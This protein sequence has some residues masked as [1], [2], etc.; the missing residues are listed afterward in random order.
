MVEGIEIADIKKVLSDTKLITKLWIH[1]VNRD[2]VPFSYGVEPFS[3]KGNGKG[4]M[5][6]GL[7]GHENAI[8]ELI[9]ET[10]KLNSFWQHY[11]E[12]K[13]AGDKNDLHLNSH[14]L[15][16]KL[17]GSNTEEYERLMKAVV[18]QIIKFIKDTNQ[19][20]LPIDDKATVEKVKKEVSQ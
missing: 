15:L 18:N 10:N 6:V 5:F 4:A 3:A 11:K 1:Y 19:Y 13:T 20:V 8:C 14:N 17:G 2:N 7:F 16:K 9:P 12:L